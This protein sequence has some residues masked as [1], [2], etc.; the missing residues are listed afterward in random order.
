MAKLTG[1]QSSLARIPVDL[2]KR[3]EFQFLGLDPTTQLYLWVTVPVGY[4]RMSLIGVRIEESPLTIVLSPGG[5]VLGRVDGSGDVPVE[6]LSIVA[7]WSLQGR[8][9]PGWAVA[10]VGSDGTFRIVGVP[11]EQVLT[12]SL[13]HECSAATGLRSEPVVSLANA[14]NVVVRLKAGRIVEGSVN[15]KLGRAD[16]T[17]SLHRVGLPPP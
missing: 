14:S 8:W 9:D 3:G 5:V 15:A 2:N 1:F 11:V 7:T 17:A 13:T 4:R 6:Q 16:L 10:R 12:L